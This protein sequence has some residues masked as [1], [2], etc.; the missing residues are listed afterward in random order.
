M[1]AITANNWSSKQIIAYNTKCTH[2]PPV[3][4]PASP[5]LPHGSLWSLMNHVKVLHQYTRLLSEAASGRGVHS[6]LMCGSAE[7]CQTH[8]CLAWF[9]LLCAPCECRDEGEYQKHVDLWRE[10]NPGL[11]SH[12]EAAYH[13]HQGYAVEDRNITRF[14][15]SRLLA[16]AREY[17]VD[18]AGSILRVHPAPASAAS[19]GWRTS[20]TAR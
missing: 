20:A 12:A 10:A 7:M 14:L 8:P 5:V 4:P 6:P 15:V 11:Y 13:V 19:T 16:A 3:P 2:A 1:I 18:V 9:A 17:E